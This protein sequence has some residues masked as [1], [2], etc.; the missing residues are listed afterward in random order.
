[1]MKPL[2]KRAKNFASKQEQAGS[3]HHSNLTYGF[4]QGYR[5]CYRDWRKKMV[6]DERELARRFVFLADRGLWQAYQAE[7]E[8][9]RYKFANEI[10]QPRL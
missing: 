10:R 1:M 7:I 3:V 6:E 2:P 5:A 8:T 9:E 4:M